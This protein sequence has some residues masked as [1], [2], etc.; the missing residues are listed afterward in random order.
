[1]KTIMLVLFGV[2]FL[3]GFLVPLQH[4]AGLTLQLPIK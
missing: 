3:S 2:T 4:L 1:M